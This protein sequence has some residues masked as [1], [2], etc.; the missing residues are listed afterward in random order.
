AAFDYLA[1]HPGRIF[2]E[3]TWGDY[4]IA[5]GRRTFADGRTDLFSGPVLREF[6]DVANLTTDPEPILVAYDVRYV[7]W[8]RDT[9]LAEFLLHSPH[10]KVV[11][12]TVPALVFERRR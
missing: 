2:T 3:Y 11:D 9:P 8:G 10:W 7:V 6:F 5:R 12:R 1:S 4:S